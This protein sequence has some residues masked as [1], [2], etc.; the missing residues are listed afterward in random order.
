LLIE[1]EVALSKNPEVGV[2]PDM[3]EDR[4]LLW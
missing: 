3:Q 4:R 2:L 1:K